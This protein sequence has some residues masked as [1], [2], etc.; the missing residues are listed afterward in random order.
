MSEKTAQGLSGVA[1]TLLITL[2][3]RAFESQH[4]DALVKDERAEA[5][6]SQM[7]LDFLRG[8][9]ASVEEYIQV[10]T[11]LRS[12]EFDRHAQEF[13]A[14]HPQAV[15]V[16]I[17]CGLDARFE[18]VGNRQVEW[19]DL[20]LPHVIDLHRKLIGGEEER[21]H[22]LA[23]SVL[24]NAWLDTASVH[25]QRPLLF[26]AEGVFMY[27][28]EAKVKSLML[29]LRDRFPGS[30]LVFDALSPLH[31]WRHNLQM[32]TF[33]VAIHVR[34]GIW[35]GQELEGWGAGIRLLN[36]WGFFDN[37]TPRLDRI[38]WLRPI[39]ALDRTLRIY[40]FQLGKAAG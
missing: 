27:F 31:V 22:F 32:R 25:R 34:W 28:A 4:P 7:D 12:R 26:L 8:K 18:R 1:E 11:I 24:D 29:T 35:H 15:V 38:R 23:C 2:A 6:V 19:F 17:G 36:E 37:P 30:E 9:L 20:D 21:H 16:H 10:A 13:L 3:I 33:K 40:H 14:R 39:E 5:L